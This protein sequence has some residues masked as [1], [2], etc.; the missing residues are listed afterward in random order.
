MRRAGPR[1]STTW[2]PDA[3]TSGIMQ[4][5]RYDISRP[6]S[7]LPLFPV[8][9]MALSGCVR[10]HEDLTVP[11]VSRALATE[12]AIQLDSVRYDLAFTIPADLAQPVTG[13]A[14]IA[15]RLVDTDRPVVLDFVNPAASV[16][17]VRVKDEPVTARLMGE[18]LVI[19]ASALTAG[20]NTVEIAFTAGDGPLH[21]NPEFLYTLF[22][23]D[24]A[25]FAFPC[26]DQPDLKARVTLA[27]TIP[28]GWVAVANGAELPEA[29]GAAG[30]AGAAA[31][32]AGST[33]VR[34][35]ETKPIPTYLIA[36]AAG[37]FRVE[38]AVRNGRRLRMFHRETDTARVARNRDA[39]FDL[40]AAALTW[41]EAY[42][43]IPYPFD[44]FDFVAVPAFQY[45][46][47][48]HPGA[49]LY[50]ASS[51]FLEP[52]ATQAELL[53]RA[54]LMAHETAHMWFGDLVTMRWFDDVWMKEVF[55]NFM[56]AKIVN[57]SFPTINHELR[58][59]LAHYPAAYDV[60]R[61]AGANPIRQP[62]GNLNEAGTLYGAIIYQKAPIVMRQLE[63]LVGDSAFRD[64]LREYLSSYQFGNASWPD[65]IQLLDAR[66][67]YDL[68][69][70]SH[71]WVEEPGRPTITTHLTLGDG[72]AIAALSFAQQDPASRG[73][74]WPQQLHPLLGAADTAPAF[75]LALD[76]AAA[77]VPQAA[78]RPAPDFVLANGMGVAYGDFVPD[79]R[80]LAWLSAHLPEIPD[81]LVRGIAW[82]TLWD[83]MLDGR[84]PPERLFDLARR[85]LPADSTE[86]NV[87]RMLSD[88]GETYWRFL[89]AERRDALAPAVE[90]ALW[91]G[92]QAAATI[93]LKAAYF[94]AYRGLAL[95]PA[96]V[97]RLE[98]IWSR[99]E[100]VG[101]LPLA[102]RDY[103]ALALELAVREVPRWRDILGTQLAR[104]TNPER[105]AQFAFVMPALSAD[106]S[107][108][109]A[110]FASLR[111]PANRTHEP[112]VLEAVS[113]LHHP[114]R[115]A[116]AERYILPSLELLE[117]IQRTGDIFFPLSWL[118]ATLDGHN[119]PSA[120]HIV[121]DFLAARPDYPARLRAKILQAADELDRSAGIVYGDSR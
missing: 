21:R 46:G 42:T 121:R 58:F 93:S 65:L 9:L 120:A 1:R 80:S 12:R 101:G 49:V 24:R 95:T 35:A 20:D 75:D 103:T 27:L 53:G 60:D 113:Y 50:R 41:L 25:R 10:S 2:R 43:G 6:P 54:S 17:S 15:F 29:A 22:V 5:T 48:E 63:G 74:L 62:L 45:S 102:E 114:L 34:F 13:V 106:T 30:A 38:E 44:K 105:K 33:T 26:F 89:P 107:V 32:A 55:A 31:G 76:S 11:G 100:Q 90:Q 104:I 4:L 28:E 8:L 56:A 112:W 72:S 57:P 18:H 64:G 91:D 109:D 119:T 81:E 70:W 16:R 117:E 40:E 36:F 73:R 19:P 82:L 23:P 85:A 83:A 97:A 66:T 67:S 37:R 47:M 51:L 14:R 3:L 118:N 110:F 59:L 79:A 111:D 87:Q 86:L 108:R 88:L 84:L 71:M 39:I 61:T 115:A 99:R 7:L 98:R 94:R 116:R 78:G 68:A 69:A 96:A 92:L 77:D 52:S